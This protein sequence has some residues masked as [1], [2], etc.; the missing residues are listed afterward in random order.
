MSAIIFLRIT[1]A[2]SSD[3][4]GDISEAG[5]TDSPSRILRLRE[6]NFFL[7][8]GHEKSPKRPENPLK[9]PDS[10]GGERAFGMLSFS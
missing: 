4:E 1:F 3:P 7:P 6:K 9:M 8:P 10:R 5:M 2:V